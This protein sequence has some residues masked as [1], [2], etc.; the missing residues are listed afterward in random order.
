MQVDEDTSVNVPLTLKLMHALSLESLKSILEEL[1]EKLEPLKP[2]FFLADPDSITKLTPVSKEVYDAF[3]YDAVVGRKTVNEINPK[4]RMIDL[5]RRVSLGMD[6]IL[7]D[8]KKKF[9]TKINTLTSEIESLKIASPA[10]RSASSGRSNAVAKMDNATDVS[11]DSNRLIVKSDW[12]KQ[13]PVFKASEKDCID[14][15]IY[16]VEKLA[17]K[18]K[19]KLDDLVD[20]VTPYLKDRALRFYRQWECENDVHSWSSLKKCFQ[21]LY[22]TRDMQNKLRDKLLM[23]KTTKNNFEENVAKF[24]SIV[25]RIVNITE[26]EKIFLFSKTLADNVRQLVTSAKPK[27]LRDAIEQAQVYTTTLSSNEKVN[28]IKSQPGFNKRNSRI[29]YRYNGGNKFKEKRFDTKWTSSNRGKPTDK[30]LR[31]YNCN[32]KGHIKANCRIKNPV[33]KIR[34]IEDVDEKYIRT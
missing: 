8:Q 6:Q 2:G 32:K 1:L 26:D 19:V 34:I 31:C 12:V 25:S 27:T 15:W 28:Y 13:I 33:N 10:S 7:E 9:Q 16:I 23:L 17:T 21:E 30:S 11:N 4:D 14:E 18:N 29:D 22:N 24:E 5:I 20:E 3:I